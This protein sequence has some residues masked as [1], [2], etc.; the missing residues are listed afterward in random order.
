LVLD[1]MSDRALNYKRV[2]VRDQYN[3]D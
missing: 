3:K 2:Y 1:Y